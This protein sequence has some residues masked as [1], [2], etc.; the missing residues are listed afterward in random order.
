[1][2]N[3]DG[4]WKQAVYQYN[5]LGQRVGQ[6]IW[7]SVDVAG[8]YRQNMTTILGQS[9]ILPQNAEHPIYLRLYKT[10]S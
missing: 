7:N 2:G 3:V 8:K 1:M 10:V 6:K 5:G 9:A 4:I